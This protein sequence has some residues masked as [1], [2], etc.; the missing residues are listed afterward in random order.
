[1]SKALVEWKNKLSIFWL[2]NNNCFFPKNS[3]GGIK[4]GTIHWTS[5]ET[6]SIIGWTIAINRPDEQDHLRLLYSYTNNQTREKENMDY[7]IQLVTTNCNYGSKRYWFICPIVKNNQYCGRRVGVLYR[8]GKYFGCRHCGELA[9]T[10][11]MQSEKYK[12]F[13]SI[14]D[15]ERAEAKVKRQY[16]KGRPT[17]KYRKVMKLNDKFEYGL[18]KTVCKLDKNFAQRFADIGK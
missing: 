5:G 14:P 6:E 8:I 9:Y 2:K 4:S 12:G 17:R 18:F 13:V 15:I 16:Y 10:S 7:K 3:S 1:M 11:Q